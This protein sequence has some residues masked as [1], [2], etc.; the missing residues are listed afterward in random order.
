MKHETLWKYVCG[1]PGTNT[2]SSGV[3]DDVTEDP[4]VE[5]CPVCRKRMTITDIEHK[6][7]S[8]G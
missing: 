3:R 4:P 8:D 1:C 2:L 6:E 7:V 5:V